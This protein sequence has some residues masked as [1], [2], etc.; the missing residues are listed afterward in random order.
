MKNDISFLILEKSDYSKHSQQILEFYKA[1][2]DF[3][4]TQVT[5]DNSAIICLAMDS[6]EIIGAVRAIS[7]LSRHAEIVDLIVRKA[8]RKQQVGTKLVQLVLERL[9]KYKVKN[10]GLTTEPGI[11]WLIEFYNKIGFKPL[12]RNAYLEYEQKE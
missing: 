10:I 5:T 8:Y 3:P 12:E 4:Y 9:L 1:R 2:Y 7:D 6:N 11:E